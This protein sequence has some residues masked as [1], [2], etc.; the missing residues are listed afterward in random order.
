VLD[1]R[2]QIAAVARHERAGLARDGRARLG[3]AVVGLLLLVGVLSGALYYRQTSAERLAAG[4]TERERWVHQPAKNSH[5]ATHYGVYVFKPPAPLA[6]LERGIESFVGSGVWLEAHRTNL[7]RHRPVEDAT[8]VARFGELTAAL[9]LQVLAPLVI[10]LAGHGAVS[11]E[12]ESGRW[13]QLALSGARGSTIVAG[14]LCGLLGAAVIA[15]A[16]VATLSAAALLL[17][18]LGPLD[19]A[20]VVALAAA[21]AAYLAG[22]AIL[23]IAVSAWTRSVRT[24]LVS[25]L[26]LWCLGCVVGPRLVGDAAARAYPVPSHVAFRQALDT[27]IGPPSL[28]RIAERKAR[29]LRQYGVARTEDLPIDW[30]GINLQEEEERTSAIFQRHFDG[31]LATY[32]AQNRLLQAAGIVVPSLAVQALS[33]AA[34]GTDIEH[35][36][37]FVNDAEAHRR[38]IQRLM[39]ADV[40]AHDR[41]GTD[42]RANPQLWRTVPPFSPTVVSL[43]STLPSISTALA[44]L[45]GWLA[46]VCLACATAIRRLV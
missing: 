33:Q 34:A 15:G 6:L 26:V 19:P 36:Q 46:M 8:T 22:W 24:A 32:R 4:V 10:I 3:L 14:K 38:E 31:L 7:F 42:Y 1:Q 37:R 39:N 5:D 43:A 18:R 20:R 13:R 41:E 17:T 9:A 21:Y 44:A 29:I 45:V 25:L 23:V 2:T 12:R 30:R 28:E 16:P 27:D 11:G 40:T 35:H